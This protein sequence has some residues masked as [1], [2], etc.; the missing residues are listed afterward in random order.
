MFIHAVYFRLRPELPDAELQRFVTGLESL[1]TI[2]TVRRGFIGTPAAT[3][4]PVIDSSYSYA[5][6]MHFDDEAGHDA[7]QEHAV[8]EKFRQECAPLWTKVQIY[9]CMVASSERW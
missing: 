3:R 8:H 7:Y 4:R 6:I 9:D 5:L 2:E 1:T